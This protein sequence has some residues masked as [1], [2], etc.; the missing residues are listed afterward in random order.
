MTTSKVL[1]HIKLV[2]DSIIGEYEEIVMN[3]TR[4]IHLNLVIR[5]KF[6]WNQ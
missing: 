3:G 4:E 5:E 6:S 2:M 1:H